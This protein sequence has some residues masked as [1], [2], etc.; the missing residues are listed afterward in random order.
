MVHLL[1]EYYNDHKSVDQSDMQ[2]RMILIVRQLW[3]QT[4]S[5]VSAPVFSASF[6]P[7]A[8]SISFSS[9][10]EQTS[11]IKYEETKCYMQPGPTSR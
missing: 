1:G 6:G 4:C 2:M 9:F 3:I 10:T 5:S 8:S 7:T 11:S